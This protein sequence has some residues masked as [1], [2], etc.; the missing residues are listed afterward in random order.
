MKNLD[1][2][3]PGSG[4][5]PKPKKP[6]AKKINQPTRLR[7]LPSDSERDA[8]ADRRG[9][10]SGMSLQIPQAPDSE[11]AILGSLL[12]DGNAIRVR[13]RLAPTQI[14]KPSNRLIFTAM[15][16]LDARGVPLDPVQLTEE[17]R[18]AGKLDSVGGVAYLA[19]L[20]DGAIRADLDAHVGRV[21]ET[22]RKRIAWTLGNRAID[23]VNN[24]HTAAEIAALLREGADLL[25][26]DRAPASSLA[27]RWMAGV[28]REDVAWEW[29][30][31]LP[32]RKVTLLLGDP[33]IGKSWITCAIAS[34]VSTG[35]PLPEQPDRREPGNVLLLTCEDGYEDTIAPRLHAM[36]ADLGRI[37]GIDSHVLLTDKGIRE[38]ECVIAKTNPRLVTI[39][40]LTGYMGGSVDMHR[41]NE[42]R[43]VMARLKIT[44]QKFGCAILCLGHLNKSASGKAVYRALGS[45]DFVGAAR[46]A[47]LAGVDPDDQSKR[48]I[49]QIKNNLA[50]FGEPVGYERGRTDFSGP[51]GAI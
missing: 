25:T 10:E 34:A 31:F 38:I 29:F 42:V 7:D 9:K 5:L 21:I 17:L 15:L 27:W 40:T 44:A 12:L 41:A 37:A 4:D 24:G 16:A 13:D 20:T 2:T 28:E 14:F 35:A 26:T 39:D 33:G 36:G 46:S 18:A 23:A 50:A 22:A 6:T 19:S 11:R 45:I 3:I 1:C 49:V 32:R 8:G 30:P 51:V 48:A 47:L 43:E